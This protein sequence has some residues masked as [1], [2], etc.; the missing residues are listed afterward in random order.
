[1]I[2]PPPWNFPT[3]RC[4]FS[5]AWCKRSLLYD[6]TIEDM[7]IFSSAFLV[8]LRGVA[9]LTWWLILPHSPQW[10]NIW[11]KFGPHLTFCFLSILQINPQK[12]YEIPRTFQQGKPGR[13][14]GGMSESVSDES[15]YEHM[16]DNEI[17]NS[18]HCDNNGGSVVP[19]R[20]ATSEAKTSQDTDNYATI[21]DIDVNHIQETDRTIPKSENLSPALSVR[22]EPDENGY[23]AIPDDELDNYK[24]RDN[25]EEGT[26]HD[27]SSGIADMKNASTTS[28]LDNDNYECIPGALALSTNPIDDSMN[29]ANKLSVSADVH[30][31]IL[32]KPECEGLAI[33]A[34]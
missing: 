5:A 26:L 9:Q 12:Y 28:P 20:G 33:L 30:C 14:S 29:P 32:A 19:L 10:M 24:E 34:E 7:N 22:S 23:E 21:P 13:R 8:E 1:M 3:T 15:D 25:R 11:W 2:P 16:S 27:L 31:P 17:A 6:Q 18:G 4:I